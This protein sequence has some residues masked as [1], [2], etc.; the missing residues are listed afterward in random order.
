MFFFFLVILGDLFGDMFR[1][2][3]AFFVGYCCLPWVCQVCFFSDLGLNVKKIRKPGLSVT[4]EGVSS[5]DDSCF[6]RWI[7]NFHQLLLRRASIDVLWY[8]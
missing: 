5:W 8:R 4:E 3:A 7:L 1:Y 6:V 2:F